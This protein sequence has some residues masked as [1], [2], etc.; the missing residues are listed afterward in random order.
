MRIMNIITRKRCP[1]AIAIRHVFISHGYHTVERH[2]CERRRL[3]DKNTSIISYKINNFIMRSCRERRFFNYYSHYRQYFA[4][5]HVKS[6]NWSFC[7]NVFLI[8][9]AV[10]K[11]FLCKQYTLIRCFNEF[12][13]HNGD[14]RRTVDTLKYISVTVK[15]R[16]Y[17]VMYSELFKGAGSIEHVKYWTSDT[18]FSLI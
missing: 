13:H 12:W 3:S 7:E 11:K 8:R 10:R 17:T 2:V 9:Q 14:N 1:F 15:S 5:T 16:S 6:L 4:L 18:K